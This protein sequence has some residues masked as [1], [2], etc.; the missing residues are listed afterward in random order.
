[1][2]NC[3]IHVGTH[4]TG[5][6][7]IQHMLSRSSSI[8][9]GKGYLYP[10]AGRLKDDPGHHNIAWEISGDRRYEAAN[11]TIPALLQEA[12]CSDHDL[13][14]SSEDLECALYSADRFADFVGRVQSGGF[15]VTFILYVR[16]Q[17]D[18]LPRIYLTLMMFGLDA[19]FNEV[20]DEVLDRAEFRWREWIF[21][22]DYVDLLSR[23]Y[24]LSDVEVVVRSYDRV[25]ASV[26]SDFLS[27]YGLAL[28]D[29]RLEQEIVANASLPVERYLRWFVG[30]RFG[31][32]LSVAEQDVFRFV[33]GRP[34]ALQM[35]P[36]A[37]QEVNRRFRDSNRELSAKYG[38]SDFG[39]GLTTVA[40]R[41]AD[42]RGPYVDEIFSATSENRLRLDI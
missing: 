38:I 16:S 7:A 36:T 22:F 37:T 17:V 10:R 32:D 15:K 24:A 2:R 42:F 23:L 28:S 34:D 18:Y 21:D 19:A 41:N 3:F 20:L 25:S 11:G 26:C 1:M 30:N 31:R 6:T 5:T 27:I 13:I 39:A 33:A 8:L 40:T 12:S 14:L 35:S 4:K 29:L 9:A